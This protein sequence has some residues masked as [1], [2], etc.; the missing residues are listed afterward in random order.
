MVFGAILVISLVVVKTGEMTVA[1]STP[2]CLWENQHGGGQRTHKRNTQ[3]TLS[4]VSMEWAPIRG[5]DRRQGHQYWS[6]VDCPAGLYQRRT[7]DRQMDRQAGSRIPSSCSI[8][9]RHWLEGRD[10]NLLIFVSP[11]PNT[12]PGTYK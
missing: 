11:V 9:I 5:I 7:K 6:T 3:F 12:A 1:I 10:H 8:L 2:G 4:K